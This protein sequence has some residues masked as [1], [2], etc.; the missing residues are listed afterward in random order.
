MKL[1]TF[2]AAALVAASTPVLA[3]EVVVSN[4]NGFS[5]G[6]EVE[7][8]YAV[9]AEA[10]TLTVTPEATYTIG[11][12]AITA[13]AAVPVWDSVADDNFVLMNALDQGSYPA[14]GLEVTY[15]FQ[16]N[17]ELTLGTEWDFNDGA[18]EELTVSTTFKF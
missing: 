1:T 10:L 18:R 4:N 12:T 2:V 3:E 6:G 17:M 11:K 13:S 14:L 9:D 5:F 8:K 16:N 7:S 15:Q